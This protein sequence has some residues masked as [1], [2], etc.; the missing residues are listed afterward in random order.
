MLT[1]VSSIKTRFRHARRVAMPAAL[2]ILAL[3]G[4][5]AA[6]PRAA[7]AQQ[8]YIGSGNGWQQMIDHPDQWTFVRRNASGFYVNFIQMLRGDVPRC[9]Q[10]AALFTHK[11]A[12]YES[13]SRYT[14]LG[15]FPNGGQ[16][17]LALQATQLNA[18]LSGG[19]AVPYTSLNYGLDAAKEA[20]LKQIGMPAGTSRPCLTQAGP[21]NFHGDI[22]NSP[23]VTANIGR[24]DGA[25]TDG[26]LSLWQ[27]NQGMMQQGSYSLVNYVHARHKIALVMVAPYNLK[28]TSQWLSVAQQCVRQHEDH[29]AKPDIWSVFEYATTTPT[30]PETVG[31]RPADTI[32]GM[33]YWLINHVRDPKRYAGL[34]VPSGQLPGARASTFA[35]RNRSTWLDLCPAVSAQVQDP[36]HQWNVRFH[37]NGRDVTRQ[38]TQPGGLA[39]VGGLRLWPGQSRQVQVTLA[40]KNPVFAR[41]AAPPVIRLSLRPNGSREAQVNQVVTLRPGAS[42]PAALVASARP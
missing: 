12:I 32:T 9:T 25:S 28:P 38:L 34:A 3:T 35:V 1:H 22:V 6:T 2:S 36:A 14:G 33:A 10:T 21:W 23:D 7:Q 37:V 42:S 24:S 27:V 13:D 40:P 41:R 15:G 4:A 18:L 19:F 26:P 31:G 8:V 20:D 39:F 30:L 16:F 11:N 5:L 17:S 29:G